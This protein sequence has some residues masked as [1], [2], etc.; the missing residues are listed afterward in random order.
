MGIA[1][2]RSAGRYVDGEFQCYTLEDPVRPPGVKIPKNTA[3]PAGTYKLVLDMSVRFSRLMP[4]ILN[5]PMF[6]GSRIHAGNTTEDTE[7]CP[8]VGNER[9]DYGR[10]VGKSRIAF[11]ALFNKLFLSPDREFEITITK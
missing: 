4:H 10:T 5:V 7:G 1:P 11:N 8:L 3:I 2:A 6:E 9:L